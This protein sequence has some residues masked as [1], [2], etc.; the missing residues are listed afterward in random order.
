MITRVKNSSTFF[1]D[2]FVRPIKT[3]NNNPGGNNRGSD[4]ASAPLFLTLE[5]FAFLRHIFL[6][7]YSSR[8]DS[9]VSHSLLTRLEEIVKKRERK[10]ENWIELE[11]QVVG[12]I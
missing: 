6:D 3:E 10:R 1:T 8:L 2:V 12:Y 5:L 4:E 7:I 9:P 11:S